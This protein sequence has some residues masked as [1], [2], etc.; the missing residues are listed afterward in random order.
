MRLQRWNKTTVDWQC[1]QI[2][3]DV[4]I[5]DWPDPDKEHVHTIEGMTAISLPERRGEFHVRI[6]RM[7]VAPTT[8][9]QTI[10]DRLSKRMGS[11]DL[12]LEEREYISISVKMPA[13]FSNEY[14]IEFVLGDGDKFC[15]TAIRIARAIFSCL[16]VEDKLGY[17]LGKFRI[18]QETFVKFEGNWIRFASWLRI[19][20]GLAPLIHEESEESLRR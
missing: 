12:G 16:G 18:I 14:L 1:Y 17:Q 19:R 4:P 15:D 13:Q 7:A 9:R 11:G 3:T 10:Y 5:P 8:E 6:N 2:K 20:Y